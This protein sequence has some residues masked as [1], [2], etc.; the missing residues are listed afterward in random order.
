MSWRALNPR[1]SSANRKA[2]SGI[3]MA[4]SKGSMVVLVLAI[5]NTTR[6]V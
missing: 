3:F 6:G 4:V 5:T 2:N 1:H